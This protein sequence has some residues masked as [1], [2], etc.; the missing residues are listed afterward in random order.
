VEA[1]CYP[2]CYRA[3]LPQLG[4]S[5]YSTPESRVEPTGSVLLHISG[6]VAVKVERRRHGRVPEALLCDLGM[7]TGGQE[8]RRLPVAQ[9]LGAD[10][11]KV[12]HADNES[13]KFM[14]EALRLQRLAVLSG[15]NERW[16]ER[17]RRREEIIAG[18]NV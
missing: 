17:L 11:W 3:S 7:D 14:R 15:T 4:K 12:P 10:A 5:I 13:L 8:L 9:I 2:K 18:R 1:Q 16:T 6:D